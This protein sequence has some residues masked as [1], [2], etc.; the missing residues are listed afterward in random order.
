MI[1]IHETQSDIR[2]SF[3]IAGLVV[4]NGAM[5]AIYTAVPPSTKDHLLALTLIVD[6]A[7]V[8]WGW[9]LARRELKS[10]DWILHL[11][12]SCEPGGVLRGYVETPLQK[13]PQ[14][15]VKLTFASHTGD[16]LSGTTV[17]KVVAEGFQASPAGSLTVP[18]ELCIPRGIAMPGYYRDLHVDGEGGYIYWELQCSVGPPVLGYVAR[19]D[20]PALVIHRDEMSRT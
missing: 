16:P 9:A 18:V 15:G 10:G 19:F 6:M 1:V 7:V 20:V 17:G 14:G 4:W 3:I 2:L 13:E 5:A 12:Q 11:E 8:A